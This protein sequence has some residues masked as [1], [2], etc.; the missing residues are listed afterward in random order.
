M[1]KTEQQTIQQFVEKHGVTATA[2]PA[3]SNP[4]AEDWARDAHHWKVRLRILTGGMMFNQRSL[5]VPFSQGSA[6]TTPPTAADVLGCLVMDS[7]GI[8]NG[9]SFEDWCAEY[10]YDSDSRKAEK[11]FKLC[12]RQARKLRQFL[13]AAYDEAMECES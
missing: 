10:G 11:T 4:N 12:E 8:D 7:S 5:T 6:H 13:G 2:T 1:S 9:T 3:E